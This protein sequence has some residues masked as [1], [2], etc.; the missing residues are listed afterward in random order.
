MLDA[1][2]VPAQGP[3]NKKT[4][5][6]FMTVMLADGMIAS[7]QTGP[8]PRVSNRGH[9]YIS[10]FYVYDAFF[11]GGTSEEKALQSVAESI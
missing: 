2:T 9:R 3:S 10:V 11:K 4:N 7:D 6:V 1:M 5:L 8:F